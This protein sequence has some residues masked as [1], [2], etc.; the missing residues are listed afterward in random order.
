MGRYATVGQAAVTPVGPPVS[1]TV[2]EVT[3][4]TVRVRLDGPGDV[5]ET[6]TLTAPAVAG[7]RCLVVRTA[8]ETWVTPAHTPTP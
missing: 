5:P 1:G 8:T 3:G 4:T 6:G 2:V 7:V